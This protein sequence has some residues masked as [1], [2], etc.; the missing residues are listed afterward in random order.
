VPVRLIATCLLGLV[1]TLL[2]LSNSLVAVLAETQ[3]ALLN[4]MGAAPAQALVNLADEAMARK[5]ATPAD[6]APEAI[7]AD[8]DITAYA[9]Q[10][11]VADPLNASALRI[12]GQLAAAGGK[13]SE[14]EAFMAAAA[15]RNLHEMRAF[16]WLLQDGLSK[17]D[18]VSA[19]T[20]ADT[21]LRTHSGAK[22]YA[23]QVLARLAEDDAGRK[24]VVRVLADNP[25]W[26][27]GVLAQMPA[28]ARDARTL[29]LVLQDLKKTDHPPTSKDVVGYL[30]F[31][32]GRKLYDYAYYAWLQ[33]LPPEQLGTLGF[34]SNGGFE[35]PP[36]GAPFDWSLGQGAGSTVKIENA[37]DASGGHALF[38]E[39]GLGRVEFSGVRQT[40]MLVPGRYR[41]SGRFRG[42][43]RAARGLEWRVACLDAPA[44]P[45][46]ATDMFI[47][48]APS[49]QPFETHF[50]VPQDKCVGQTVS[51]VLNARLQSERI[52]SGALW[53]DEIE[54]DAAPAPA[55][56]AITP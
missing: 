25:A 55:A 24:E 15:Q 51:L 7:L 5:L 9:E 28:H 34:L 46:G 41:L 56:D 40:T 17:G 42:E 43:M 8:A 22:P 23:V 39:F 52:V 49:W 30:N 35:S 11:L 33:F 4:S 26:R 16:A 12:L 10:A 1:A 14:A 19:A 3:P 20:Y 53:F 38:V 13:G 2:V 54:I 27:A 47:K 29:F 48:P 50:V 44:A 6:A 31:L 21:L 45:L 32:I 37:P 18:R 36:S